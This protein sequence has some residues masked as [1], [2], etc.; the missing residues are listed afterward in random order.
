M[1]IVE[2]MGKSSQFHVL[3]FDRLCQSPETEFAALLDFLGH[4]RPTEVLQTLARLVS[5]PSSIGRYRER[6]LSVFSVDDL[7]FVGSL[8]FSV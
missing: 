5:P 3:N 1:R 7:D 4:D 8:G 2:Q 6:D